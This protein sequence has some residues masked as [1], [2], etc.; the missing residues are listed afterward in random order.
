MICL[1]CGK[2]MTLGGPRCC[3]GP[4]VPK[5]RPCYLHRPQ[6]MA[7]DIACAPLCLA[8]DGGVYLVGSCLERSDYRDVDVRAI[9]GRAAWDGMFPGV[10]P[11][12]PYMNPR[13]EMFNLALSEFLATRTKLP[14]DFQVQNMDAANA[15]FPGRRTALGVR[16]P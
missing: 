5:K 8:F 3:N 15:E 11:A 10:D 2:V 13:W 9:V 1:N 16:F 7:L 6:L 14:I 4:P 12:K